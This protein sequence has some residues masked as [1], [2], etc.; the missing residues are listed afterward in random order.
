ML[1]RAQTASLFLVA[2]ILLV[3]DRLRRRLKLPGKILGRAPSPD[4]IKYL[5]TELR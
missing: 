5:A 1:S 4:Q 3:S 2:T